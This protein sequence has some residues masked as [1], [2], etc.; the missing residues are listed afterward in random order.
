MKATLVLFF[1]LGVNNLLMVY[2]PGDEYEKLYI[3]A[4]SVLGAT[5]VDNIN[6]KVKRPRKTMLIIF[7]SFVGYSCS[8]FVLFYEQ[9]GTGSPSSLC[10]PYGG[11]LEFE[12]K[13]TVKVLDI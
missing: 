2:N 13:T 6:L 10:Q 9:R 4:N 7:I 11:K 5:Q 12:Q 8:V 1:V 3:I